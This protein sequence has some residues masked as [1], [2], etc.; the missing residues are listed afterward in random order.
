VLWF[1]DLRVAEAVRQ[2]VTVER[3]NVASFRVRL[4][5]SFKYREGV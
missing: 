5:L 1:I 2:D 4:N 3:E